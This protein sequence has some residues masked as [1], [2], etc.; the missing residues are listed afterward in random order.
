MRPIVP[1]I[2]GYLRPAPPG[3]SYSGLSRDQ[4]IADILSTPRNGEFHLK[5][6]YP[7]WLPDPE[8]VV[9]GVWG[10]RPD[11]DGLDSLRLIELQQC[12]TG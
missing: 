8:D 12:S 9:L 5:G 2:A 10:T 7:A 11:Y 1:S 3:S 4:I 6:D